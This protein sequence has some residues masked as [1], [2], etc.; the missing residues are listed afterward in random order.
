L[1]ETAAAFTNC[2]LLPTM[3]AILKWGKSPTYGEIVVNR[4]YDGERMARKFIGG[5]LEAAAVAAGVARHVIW[6]VTYQMD[7]TTHDDVRV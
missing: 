3:V 2:G 6:Y 4:A 7:G 5:A 1:R